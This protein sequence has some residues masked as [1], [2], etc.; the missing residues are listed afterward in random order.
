[1]DIEVLVATMGQTDCSLAE[2]MNIKTSAVIANQSQ[3]WDYEEADRGRVRMLS[4]DTKGVGIN[5]N[6][7]LELSKGDILLLADDDMT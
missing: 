6:F 3:R 4:T 2:K 7:A 5:R 1:M